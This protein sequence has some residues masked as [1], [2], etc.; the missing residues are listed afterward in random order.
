MEDLEVNFTAELEL[1]AEVSGWLG[2][3][4]VGRMFR[5]EDTKTGHTECSWKTRGKWGLRGQ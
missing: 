2:G 5:T 1:V 4:V 3:A